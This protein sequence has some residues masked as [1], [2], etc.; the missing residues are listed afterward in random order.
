MAPSK[1]TRNPLKHLK[2]AHSIHHAKVLAN[3][4]ASRLRKAREP[5]RCLG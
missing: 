3:K 5:R 4:H 2:R 1:D